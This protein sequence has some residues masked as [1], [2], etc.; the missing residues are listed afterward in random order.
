MEVRGWSSKSELSRED[1]SRRPCWPSRVRSDYWGEGDRP[2]FQ[3]LKWAGMLRMHKCGLTPIT[4]VI[5]DSITA[6]PGER[7]TTKHGNM[8]WDKM[9]N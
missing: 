8:L 9:E 7:E 6:N 1:G 4:H 3:K 2:H 5:A